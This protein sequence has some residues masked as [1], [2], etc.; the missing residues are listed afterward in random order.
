MPVKKQITKSR[1]EQKEDYRKIM[2]HFENI[3]GESTCKKCYGRGYRHWDV[4][5]EY[6][7]PCD[8]LLEA[9]QKLTADKLANEGFETN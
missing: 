7:V 1:E 8:C 6:Y 9:E 5:V 3:F 4:E 2:E